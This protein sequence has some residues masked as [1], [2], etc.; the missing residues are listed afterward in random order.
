MLAHLRSDLQVN[1]AEAD[2][3]TRNLSSQQLVERLGLK[4]V[5]EV[6]NADEFKGRVSDEYHY[7]LT[8]S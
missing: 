5:R 2:I 6:K 7:E 4:R 8:L 1:R 3:D